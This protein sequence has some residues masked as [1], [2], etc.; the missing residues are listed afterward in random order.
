M[1]PAGTSRGATISFNTTVTD[2]SVANGN[3][4][5]TTTLTVSPPG[6]FITGENVTMTT[7]LV[8]DDES[9][10]ILS[11]Q[12]LSSLKIVILI[13]ISSPVP[14]VI[15]VQ[16]ANSEIV[17]GGVASFTVVASGEGLTYQW[18]LG[19]QGSVPAPLV[20]GPGGISGAN[21]STLV[22]SPPFTNVSSPT[23]LSLLVVVSNAV[24]SSASNTVTLLIGECTCWHGYIQT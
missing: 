7:L 1:F 5:I 22:L 2:D 17:I 16:P 11:V 24:G 12:F 23:G 10:Q 14:P 18:M 9:K 3:R 21:E 20:D 19:L 4:L 13:F 6:Q 8:V 15:S